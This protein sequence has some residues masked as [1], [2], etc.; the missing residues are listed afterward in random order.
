MKK[1]I[2][3]GANSEIGKA[4]CECL[5]EHDYYVIACI[6]ENDYR[7]KK[8]VSE[9]LTIKRV[10]L[11]NENEIKALVDESPSIIV[12]AAAYYFDDELSE[13]TKE[14]FMR[15]LE[16]NVVAPLLLAKLIKDGIII[17]ISSTDAFDTYNE[18]NMTYAASKAALNNLTK[19]LAYSL[20]NV[21]V[22][23]LAL[24]WVDTLA[25]HEIN[26]DYLNSEMK[27][28]NQVRLVTLDEIKKYIGK[29]L[30]NEYESGSIIRI[31][32]EENVY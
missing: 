31:D 1:A 32:G 16:V 8:I 20:S 26:Q 13:T 18:I 10:D 28:N 27:R 17:N 7:I 2:V 4:I 22:Y 12:N 19:S 21:K 9:A 6:H 11:T 24:G 25:I 15:T 14:N 3:T 5:L 29:I 23:A 30:N